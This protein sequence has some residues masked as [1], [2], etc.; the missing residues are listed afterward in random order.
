MKMIVLGY[1]EPCRNCGKAP[2]LT[3]VAEQHDG[4]VSLRYAMSCECGVQGPICD[5]AEQAIDAWN[6]TMGDRP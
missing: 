2:T 3:Q 1:D 5:D 6:K 4:K